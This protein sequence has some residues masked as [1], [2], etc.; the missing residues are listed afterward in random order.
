[1]SITIDSIV[2]DV[3]LKVVNR[4]AE[5]LFKY[6][7]RTED[8]HLQ[9]ELIGV[10]YNYDVEAGM[11]ANNVTDYAALWV[12]I[13]EPVENHE[14]TMPDESGTLTFDCYFANIRDEVSKTGATNYFRNLAFSVIAVSPARTP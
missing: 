12:K 4:K 9:S 2:Y 14:I 13:T 11:S 10:F 6:A 1:M 5:M 8:G 7:E 3:P